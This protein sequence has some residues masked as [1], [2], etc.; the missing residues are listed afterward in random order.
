MMTKS[1]AVCTLAMAGLLAACG[2]PAD[3]PSWQGT[4]ADSAGVAMVANPETGVWGPDDPWQMVEEYRV[5]GLEAAEQ[6][7]F[8]LVVGI[9]V[10][11]NGNVYAA[12]QQVQ[13]IQVFGPD[14][15]YLRT[16]G[17]P[18]GGPGEIGQALSGVWVVGQEVWAADLGNIRLNRW[19]LDGESLGS[20]PI[21]FSRGVPVRWDRVGEALVAQ[22]R[23]IAALG[24]GETPTGDL[25][26]T[27]GED[28]QDTVMTLG[29]GET[30]EVTEG[31]QA[32]MTLFE[33]EP[34]WDAAVDGRLLSGLNSTYRIEVRDANGTLQRVITKP[35]TKRP[36]SDSDQA[37]VRR[38][39]RGL[40]QAQGAPP[41]AV[42]Q[43][44]Q[45]V[46]FADNWPVMVQVIA[47]PNGTVWV[48]RLLTTDDL[49]A[50]DAEAEFNPQDLG[51]DEWD[52]FDAEGR[53]LGVVTMP[54][55][56]TPL[57]VE[58]DT[59]WGVQRDEFDV[60]SIVRF[61]LVRG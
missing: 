44:M 41:Q 1:D 22:L 21:D 25:V 59:F 31:G 30:I 54:S 51:S 3:G 13:R 27:M 32:R 49:T 40:M 4:I 48:Q 58:G 50:G 12:D 2:G 61:R 33:Q 35:Y 14:G 46:G 8:G 17:S 7:E 37:Q 39:L 36:V 24:M 10:D 60:N 15:A 28:P 9:D 20:I 43:F 5:G 18:G 6:A 55:K 38:A 16:L 57:R 56:F 34:M 47:G 45:G 19:S 42:E 11:G 53:Y 52:V 29:R 26:V 23:G